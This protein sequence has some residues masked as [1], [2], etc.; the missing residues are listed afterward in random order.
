MNKLLLSPTDELM[1]KDARPMAGSLAGH[2]LLWPTPDIIHHALHAALHR[3][4]L[5]GHR[6]CYH[7]Q[8]QAR[9]Y[10][11][12]TRVALFG[13][14]TQAGPFPVHI[15]TDSA[16][17][18]KEEWYFPCPL[19]IE[20]AGTAPTTFPVEHR[21][22]GDSLPHPLRYATAVL[23]APDKENRAP[24]WLSAAEWQAYVQNSALPPAELPANAKT[25]GKTSED[26]ADT[27]FRYGI[28]RRDDTGTVEQGRFYS[29]TSLRLRD[30]WR[31]GS[32]V[33]SAEKTEQRGKRDDIVARLFGK[34]GLK[35]RHIVVGGQQRVCT[36]ELGDAGNL[37][38][39]GIPSLEPAADG[40]VRVKWVLLTPAIWSRHGAHPGG[41]LP[42]WVDAASGQVMLCGG[43]R[44]RKPGEPRT[45]W[46][47][48][49]Q[50]EASP[51][52]AHL[53]AAVVG[54]PVSI[55][56]YAT[57]GRTDGAEGPKNTH[58]AA[59]AGS[60]Y[61]FECDSPAAAAELCRALHCTETPSLIRR[62]ELLGEQGFGLGLCAPWHF[63]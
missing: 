40:K 9:Q 58:M 26:I 46:R 33:S 51:I 61:Y 21:A 18:T 36:A 25:C 54:K 6:H 28:A 20:R 15:D 52:A 41:W 42:T 53:V 60:V 16:G 59:P 44:S 49:L 4:K 13:S 55:T 23:C 19:D 2:T 38:L 50:R 57:A 7:P 17:K 8:G 10:A 5:Q 14:V 1:L 22:G 39:P 43:D 47:A 34:D 11:A 27:E 12:E 3:S 63:A 35:E 45:E 37:P 32:W 48:R 24:A 30:D 56:G 29:A 62:S 31:M